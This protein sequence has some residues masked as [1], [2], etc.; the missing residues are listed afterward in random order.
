MKK[1]NKSKNYHLLY[2]VVDSTPKFKKFTTK[3]SMGKFI[4]K[5]NKDHPDYLSMDSGDWIDF[6]I[7]DVQGE[8][9]FFTDGLEVE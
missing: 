1:V 3:E 2:Y 5:F 9:H 6:A 7:T 4:D 8:I